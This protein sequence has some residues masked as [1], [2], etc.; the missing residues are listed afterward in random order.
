MSVHALVCHPVLQHLA[1]HFA[2]GLPNI[3]NYA[4]ADPAGSRKNPDNYVFF[5]LSYWYWSKRKYGN[6]RQ[7]GELAPDDQPGIRYSFVDGTASEKAVKS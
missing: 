2:D 6:D 5:T 3:I 1:K 7:S 4:K